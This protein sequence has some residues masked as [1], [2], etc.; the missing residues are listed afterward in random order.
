MRMIEV[1]K[2]KRQLNPNLEQIIGDSQGAKPT[3]SFVVKS[4]YVLEL[5]GFVPILSFIVQCQVL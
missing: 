4:C 3:L 5:T 1:Q 2:S